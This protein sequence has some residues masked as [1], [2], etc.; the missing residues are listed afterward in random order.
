M[1][2]LDL[3]RTLENFE[4]DL[5]LEPSDYGGL[6]D[7]DLYG[8]VALV[9]RMRANYTCMC[10]CVCVCANWL[11]WYGLVQTLSVYVC[12]CVRATWLW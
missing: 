4:A 7:G 5:R 8:E 2:A 11:W 6:G 9:V 12:V 10:I 3:E 1:H